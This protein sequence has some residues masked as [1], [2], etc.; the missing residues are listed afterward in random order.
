MELLDAV[1]EH[2]AFRPESPVE[3]PEGTRVRLSVETVQS[4]PQPQALS[5]EDRRR[6]RQRVVERM[7]RNPLP[8]GRPDSIATTRMTAIDTNILFY[9]HD[10]RDERK[11]HIAANVIQSLDDGAL[12][13]QVACGYLWAS[14]KLESQSYSYGDAWEDIEDL[15]LG[16]DTILPVWG[17]MG[18][19]SDSDRRGSCTGTP[20]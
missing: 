15:R 8:P 3:L 13:W 1:F 6:I 16:W 10:R 5:I 14:R 19:S 17:V 20:C 11:M 9:A 2:G 18:G 12:L 4:A 7:M